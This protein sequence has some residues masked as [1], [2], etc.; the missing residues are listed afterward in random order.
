MR[1]TMDSLDDLVFYDLLL[2][3]AAPI[4]WPAYRKDW[5]RFK[6]HVQGSGAKLALLAEPVCLAALGF[7]HISK[8]HV[9]PGEVAWR[10][11]VERARFHATLLLGK[12]VEERFSNLTM[13]ALPALQTELDAIA[14]GD[15]K[16]D[17]AERVYV[18]KKACMRYAYCKRCYKGI[19]AGEVSRP[20]FSQA[21]QATVPPREYARWLASTAGLAP[22]DH[23]FMDAVDAAVSSTIK[24]TPAVPHVAAIAIWWAAYARCFYFSAPPL[25]ALYRTVAVFGTTGLFPKAR[26]DLKMFNPDAILDKLCKTHDVEALPFTDIDGESYNVSCCKKCNKVIGAERAVVQASAIIPIE[27]GARTS[28]VFFLTKDVHARFKAL[29]FHMGARFNDEAVASMVTLLKDLLEGP[30]DKSLDDRMV[31]Y[32]RFI[33]NQ[34]RTASTWRE[35]RVEMRVIL[36]SMVAYEYNRLKG[37]FSLKSNET[38]LEILIANTERVLASKEV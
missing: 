1:K 26:V 5:E 27:Q 12:F 35:P 16:H 9:F 32:T 18:D 19:E 31:I 22:D 25:D 36:P 38:M 4:A 37:V 34:A 10:L 30:G 3:L 14:C 11:I 33:V 21:T 17:R 6:V 29:V 23:G 20:T 13:A 7:S 8:V 15:G 28:V 2:S 24:S